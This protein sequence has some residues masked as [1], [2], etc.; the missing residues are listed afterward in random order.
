MA[1]AVPVIPPT[2][3]P[4]PPANTRLRKRRRAGSASSGPLPETC[5]PAEASSRSTSAA[6]NQNS[7]SIITPSQAKGIREDQRETENG[8][9]RP[10]KKVAGTLAART[11]SATVRARRQPVGR[12]GSRTRRSH[13]YRWMAPRIAKKTAKKTI[14][15]SVR[16][17]SGSGRRYGSGRS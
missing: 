10:R 8:R 3:S 13:R 12:F 16:L 14:M 6:K 2:T 9:A 11:T 7:R 17:T 15:D 1:T 5:E 4:A